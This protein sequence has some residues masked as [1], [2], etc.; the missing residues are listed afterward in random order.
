MIEDDNNDN[1]DDDN[2]LVSISEFDN[3]VNINIPTASNE[4][5]NVAMDE[6]GNFGGN[7]NVMIVLQT[8]QNI[9][10]FQ[11]EVSVLSAYNDDP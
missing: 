7:S 9:N 4:T 11:S 3:E 8:N 1:D 5:A 2:Q 6:G 10:H